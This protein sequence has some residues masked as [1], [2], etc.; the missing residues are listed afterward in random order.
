MNHR[1]LGAI[2]IALLLLLAMA[3][4]GGDSDDPVGVTPTPELA[5]LVAPL[6][7][8]TAPEVTPTP[9]LVAVVPTV[10]PVAELFTINE[11]VCLQTHRTVERL[12]KEC[13][14]FR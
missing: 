10:D 9:T 8:D 1:G 13:N 14:R 12:I 2:S 11:L 7:V 5:E 3:C 6:V 4:G